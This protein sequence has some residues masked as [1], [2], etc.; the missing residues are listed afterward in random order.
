MRNRPFEPMIAFKIPF[1][2]RAHDYT[3]EEVAVVVEAMRNAT[4]LTQGKHQSAFESAFS[5]FQGSGRSFAVHTAT[6][7]LELAAQLAQFEPGDEV[8]IPVHTFTASAYPFIKHGATIRWADIDRNTRVV[9]ARTIADQITNRT[10]AIVVVHLY[11]FLAE[12]DPIVELARKHGLL[13]IEDAAQAIGCQIEGR[14][15]GSFGDFGVFSFHS[16]KNI[17]TLGEGG[18]LLVRN[19]IDDQVVRM[20]RHNGHCAFPYE[21]PDY[22]IPAMGNVDLPR[23]N[24]RDLMPSN[25]CLGEV[26]C[27]LGSLLLRR[28]GAINADKRRRALSFIDALRDS[29][30]RFHREPT[31]RHNYHLLVAEVP[32]GLRDE[33]IRTMAIQH[34]VQCVVQYCPLNR[35]D[36]YK[37]LGLAEA[38][39][40]NA[41]AFYDSMVS[42]PFHHSLGDSDLNQMLDAVR[43]TLRALAP[44]KT[45]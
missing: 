34:G 37:K 1:S 9:T 24:G 15:A 29:P 13:L 14:R 30:L 32:D 11:G 26:Q 10:K 7:A 35:Y 38:A 40:P 18:M 19:Q 16:H 28:V 39:A 45:H 12:M 20:L 3:E 36:F 22:W 5:E 23:L 33:F 27:A 42:F 43:Q 41:D 44:R 21:R 17:T 8:I 4:P 25:Y 31:E 2:G 6:A